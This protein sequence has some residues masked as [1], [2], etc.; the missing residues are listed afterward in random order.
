MAAATVADVVSVLRYCFRS[1][2]NVIRMYGYCLEPPTVCLILE[3]LPVSLKHVLRQAHPASLA[4]G[5]ASQ[6]NDVCQGINMSGLLGT[7]TIPSSS[8][9]IS[10]TASNQ[11]AGN[12]QGSNGA[13]NSAIAAARSEQLR[14]TS[15]LNLPQQSPERPE[16]LLPHAS[17]GVDT[18]RQPQRTALLNTGDAGDGTRSSVTKSPSL[19]PL[20]MMEVLRISCDVAAGLSY[21]HSTQAA[22]PAT[23]VRVAADQQDVQSG[24]MDSAGAVLAATGG[25]IVHRG[26]MIVG[27][28]AVAHFPCALPQKNTCTWTLFVEFS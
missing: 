25:R 17:D 6:G 22:I 12:A 15:G 23:S 19:K 9:H 11:L 7:T 13:L 10:I 4:S 14:R 20:T 27:G 1:H 16:L 24:S 3:L 28:D 8:V 26:A 21:L 2:P 5:S 18:D